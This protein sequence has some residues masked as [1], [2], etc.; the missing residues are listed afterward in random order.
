MSSGFLRGPT[1]GAASGPAAGLMR[2]L[3][4][5]LPSGSSGSHGLSEHKKGEINEMRDALIKAINSRKEDEKTEVLRRII[6]N[7]TLG[8]DLSDLFHHITMVR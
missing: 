3:A 1:P 8:M 4:S 2:T 5:V 7:M 6:Q